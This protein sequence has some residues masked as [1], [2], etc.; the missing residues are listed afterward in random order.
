[1]LV[2][3]KKMVFKNALTKFLMLMKLEWVQIVNSPVFVQKSSHNA[4]M[5]SATQGKTMFTALYGISP[6]GNYIPPF[7]I[8]KGVHIYESWIKGGPWKHDMHR[9]NLAGRRILYL[10]LGWIT[11]LN[12]LKTCK[13]LFS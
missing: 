8:Y 9:Q 1:M 6:S 10:S 2:L 5:K 7:A 13:S 12:V 11:L 4:Y 3:F